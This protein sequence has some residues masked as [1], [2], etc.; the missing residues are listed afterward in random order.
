[1]C[2]AESSTLKEKLRLEVE[3]LEEVWLSETLKKRCL[4]LSGLIIH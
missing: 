1:V 4:C 3:V 2:A